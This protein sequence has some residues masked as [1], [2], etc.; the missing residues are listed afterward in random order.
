MELDEFVFVVLLFEFL[1]LFA[2]FLLLLAFLLECVVVVEFD[3]LVYCSDEWGHFCSMD[4]FFKGSGG[5][6]YLKQLHFCFLAQI[7]Q[8]KLANWLCYFVFV[9]S[10]KGNQLVRILQKQFFA[11]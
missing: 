5:F 1:L 10:S 2:L 9:R 7:F 4:H 8:S 3:G 6:C 11:L